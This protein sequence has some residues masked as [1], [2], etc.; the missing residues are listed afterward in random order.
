MEIGSPKIYLISGLGAD[1]RVFKRLK[2]DFPSIPIPWI[3]PQKKEG[4]SD[5]A[6]RLSET[7]DPSEPFILIGLSLG[8]MIA[9]EMNRYLKPLATISISSI[10]CSEDLPGYFRILLRSGLV[11]YLPNWGF[12]HFPSSIMAFIFGSSEQKLLRAIIREGDPAFIKWALE[13]L[14]KWENQMIP[15]RLVQI[16]GKQDR[17]LAFKQRSQAPKLLN[18][19]H[20]IVYDQANA[21]SDCIR[22][23]L[24]ELLALKRV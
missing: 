11:P 16:H 22:Q 15:K 4:L 23:S 17:V 13:A 18:G 20:L 6:K 21:V 8:G 19:G 14:G 7:I 24:T 1:E 10:V 2:L 9:V 3:A 5:Y 12:Q